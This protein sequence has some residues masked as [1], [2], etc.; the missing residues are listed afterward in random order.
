MIREH[1]PTRY[2]GEHMDL[3]TIVIPCFQERDFIRACL[4]SVIAFEKPDDT[5]TEILVIDGMSTDGTREIIDEFAGTHP[6]I[7]RIDNANRTQSSA[8]NLGISLSHG[9]YLLRLDAHSL[10][11]SDY[12]LKTLETARR[13]GADNTGGVVN[14]L[15]RGN[16]F[17]AG[18]VQALITHPF[19]VGNSGFRTGASEGPAD[20]VPYGCFR[21]S[22]FERVGLFDERLIRA[23]DY[24][25]NRRTLATGGTVWCNPQIQ[26]QYYPQPDLATFLKKQVAAEA[27]YNA[28]MWYLAPYS[29]APRHAI[30]ALFAFG[31]IAGLLISPFS[32]TVKWTFSIVIAIYVALALIS[33][34]QQA[35]RFRDLRYVIALPPSFFL[36]H[37]LHGIGVLGGLISLLLGIAPV[38]K[39]KE[40]WPG[41]GRFRAMPPQRQSS[42]ADIVS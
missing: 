42:V 15:R 29:F 20:T 5:T 35:A 41:A 33:A 25:M 16:H 19:G 34:T 14:T 13:S 39:T 11:P 10:Y 3:V 40:P 28:Y 17:Q 26:V 32:Q 12:L 38:Q 6:S 21:T 30:T 36:Y 8:L 23:Q 7:L 27:P 24:E 4:E 37:F 1:N 9:K 18:L 22:L 31:V 2:D